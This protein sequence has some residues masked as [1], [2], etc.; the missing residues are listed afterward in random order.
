MYGWEFQVQSKKYKCENDEGELKDEHSLIKYQYSVE[1]DI[2]CDHA[3][4]S[5]KRDLGSSPHPSPHQSK[6]D[7]TAADA[8]TYG[9]KNIREESWGWS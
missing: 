3:I 2:C 9:W 7:S 6:P 5:V 1:L 8:N 4:V